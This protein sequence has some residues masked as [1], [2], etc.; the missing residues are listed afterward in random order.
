[1]LLSSDPAALTAALAAHARTA[2]VEAEYGDR[3]VSGTIATLA[4]HGPRAAQPA[5]CVA[6]LVPAP[7]DAIGL[8]HLDLD[9]L[10]GVLG[11]LGQRRAQDQS[12]WQLAAYVDVH[13]AHRL[14][15]AGASVVDRQRLVAWWAWHDAHPCYPPRDGSVLDATA[16]V[17]AASVVLSEILGDD[18]NRLA[19]GPLWLAQRAQ[20][21]ADSFVGWEG[22]VLLRAAPAFTNHLYQDPDGRVARAVVAFHQVHGALT[23]SLADPEPGVSCRQLVQEL[24]GPLAGGHDGIAGSPRGARMGLSEWVALTHAVVTALALRTPGRQ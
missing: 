9:S 20:L 8:S 2:T 13:G 18:A 19:A 12:F 7:L 4:H 16:A 17:R 1:M 5:P 11:L 15:Q 23:V 10:S 6:D 22:D 21:N 14:D 3:L 24:W